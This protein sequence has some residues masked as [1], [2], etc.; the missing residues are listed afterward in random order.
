MNYQRNR[1]LLIFCLC[2]LGALL[3]NK[4]QEAYQAKKSISSESIN[5][6]EPEL[7]SG[8]DNVDIPE[9]PKEENKHSHLKDSTQDINSL[10]SKNE[11]D[12]SNLIHV[13]TDVLELYINKKGGDIVKGTLTQYTEVNH[14]EG[15]PLLDY[16]A[17]RFYI[18]QSG[19]TSKVGPDA[20]HLGRANYASL[21][22]EYIFDKEQNEELIVDLQM[23]THGG[24]KITKRFIFTPKSYVITIKYIIHNLST[25]EYLG[26]M[27]GRFKRVI[28]EEKG[29]AFLGVQTFT[30]MA[31]Y[32]PQKPYT[33]ITF[34]EASEKPI[35]K[36]V[37][38]GWVAMIEHYF[39][40]AWIPNKDEVNQF[41]ARTFDNKVGI[42]FLS[43]AIKVAP[44]TT[45]E[46]SS[47]LY[48]GPQITE[49]LK[50][51]SPGLELTVDYGIL[52][53][54]CQPIFWLLKK[55]HSF[56]GNWGFSIIIVTLLIKALFYKLSAA[57]YRSMGNMRKLQPRMQALKERYGDDKQKFGQAVMEMYKTE[58]INPLGGCLPML[59][60]IPVFISL[61]YVILGSVE[62]HHAP[63][64]GWINDLSAKDP[65][66]ILPLLMG[67]SMFVQQK[68]SPAPPDPMQAKVMMFMPIVFTALFFN[69]PSGLVLYWFVNNL[70][71]ILQQWFIVKRIESQLPS[72][73]H[74]K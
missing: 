66:Y 32:T 1:T 46:V 56:I 42:E 54:V 69:F 74:G 16:S 64:V 70:L 40:S 12:N 71:S 10:G 65:W 67:G 27:Y 73:H 38:G 33:K 72:R 60:Q 25:H 18:A 2:I 3:F 17:N 29:S 53:P 8:V 34:K 26:Q 4:W 37:K 58:K 28:E 35:N 13:K 21:K 11:I 22:N 19:L 15:F 63:F 62:L 51:L 23:N 50:E 9:I 68:L 44:E 55:I 5:V 45:G 59:V 49:V 61:Y 39:L 47:Q 31:L 20:P 30:G 36:N 52:W 14:S 57:S 6:L 24:I 43:P 7:K 41:H 48:L